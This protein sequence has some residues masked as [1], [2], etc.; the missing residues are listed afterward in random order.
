LDTELQLTVILLED[1]ALALTDDGA[2]KEEDVV[3]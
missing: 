3:A 1:A 2:L